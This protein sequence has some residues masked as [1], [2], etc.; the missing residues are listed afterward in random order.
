MIK[1][2][3][4]FI[5]ESNDYKYGCVMVDIPINGWDSITSL[6]DEDDLYL[7]D[8][9]STYGVQDRPHVT[10]LYGLHKE[11]TLDDVKKCFNGI[12]EIV[13]NVKGISLFE[14]D[15]FDVVK[16]DV[17]KD[18]TLETIYNRLS[19]LPNSNE[20]SDYKPHITIAYVKSGL[21]R[22]YLDLDFK[23][24]DRFE[25]DEVVYSK[26]GND[27]RFN[28]GVNESLSVS[29]LDIYLEDLIDYGFDIN[30][31]V[32]RRYLKIELNFSSDKMD[33]EYIIRQY[34]S[35]VGRMA[36]DFDISY[37]SIEFSSQSYLFF[38]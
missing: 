11:V 31:M 1:S 15:K 13:L 28:I 4:Q 18:K 23:V 22:K 34:K 35:V 2:W 26:D 9:D 5:T 16:F 38:L 19:K 37:S 12:G 24:F 30:T 6:V 10:L 21:G 33:Y 25:V 17:E 36:I 14:N 32:D 8:G 27:Y 3:K 20:Y 29:S 7:G